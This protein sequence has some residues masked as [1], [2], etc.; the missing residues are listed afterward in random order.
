VTVT[1]LAIAYLCVGSVSAVIVHRRSRAQRG[2][3]KQHA[4]QSALSAAACVPL[5][6]LWAPFAVGTWESSSRGPAAKQVRRI[7]RALRRAIAAIA[8]TPLEPLWPRTALASL[9]DELGRVAE[10]LEELERCISLHEVH[11]DQTDLRIRQRATDDD[12]S[13]ATLTAMRLR[14]QA[15]LQLVTLR[16][17]NLRALEEL[18]DLV[19]L[20]AAQALVA[21]YAGSGTQSLEALVTEVR[22]R[23]DAM[24]SFSEILQ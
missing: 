6:P 13:E 16:E 3:G 4:F 21:R 7:E 24:R 9:M 11:P 18:A 20:L 1:D 8:G 10:R 22:A 19:E 17:R 5:W 12:A 15:E 2:I 23:L 14:Y